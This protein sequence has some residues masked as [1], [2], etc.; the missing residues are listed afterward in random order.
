[1]KRYEIPYQGSKNA[2]A[3]RIVTEY[4]PPS[5]CLVDIFAGG[6]AVARVRYL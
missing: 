1:M 4:L 5:T 6:C 2:I 3:S